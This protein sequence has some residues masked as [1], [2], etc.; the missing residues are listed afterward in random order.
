MPLTQALFAATIFT[1]AF[2]L[3]LVQPIVAKQI[4]PWFGGSAS[5][6]TVCMVF[7]QVLLLGGY[8][9]ADRVVRRL[10]PRAQAMLHVGLLVASLASLPIVADPAWKPQDPGA[11]TQHILG[12]LAATIGLPYFLLSTTGP[13]LQ[14]WVA[15]SPW[16]A[17]VYRYF[18]LSN[19]ASLL[20][21]LAYPVAIEPYTSLHDQALA[22]SIAY[23]VFVALCAGSALVA[24]RLPATRPLHAAAAAPAGPAEPA[25]GPGAQA[26]WL[27]LPA[28]GSWLLLA[29]TNHITQHVASI[30]F[31]WI[32]PLVVYLLTFILCFESDRWYRRGLFLPL[33]AVAL[34]LSGFGLNDAIGTH[35]KSA[36]PL[37]V[38]SL[39]VL[40]MVLHGE[41]AR[42]RPAAA[43]LTRFYLMLS[44]GGALGGIAVG[45]LAPALLTAYYELG[46]G[47]AIVAALGLAV[48]WPHRLGVVGSLAVAL[49][50]I[51]FLVEQVE[52]DRLGTRRIMRN[53]Y[54]TLLTHDVAGD[55]PRDTMRVLRHGSVIH[56]E[57]FVDPARRREPTAYYG[58]TSGAGLL[59]SNPP[60]RPVRVGVVGLGAGTLVT[61]GRPGDVYRLY[62]L[63]P[64][65]VALANEEFTFLRDTPAT[66]EHVPGDARL[67]M[68]R[69]P[70][71]GYD[72]LVIDAFSGGSVPVH[73]LT[74]EA[75]QIDLRHLRPDGVLVFH[76]TNRFLDLPPVLMLL[77][78]DAGLHAVR[79]H[80]DAEGNDALRRTDMLLMSRD[81][82]RLA[83][84]EIA[85]SVRAVEPI[86][87]LRVWTDDFN[88][89]I[90][91]L[92]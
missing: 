2:L 80:D 61:Y 92:K 75:L 16:G 45:L 1:G 22:W 9:Y 36:V 31:L 52:Y 51:G 65:V 4:L 78:R 43:H 11:P 67:S 64:Q 27:A 24:A 66:I 26:L 41:M 82:A 25:P 50:C 47:L 7:F 54:G 13:L 6:W 49:A 30:P 62:E 81:P 15:R 55:A 72:V 5:V 91:V 33:A 40:C 76:V 38:G 68:E 83:R 87:G 85:A 63:N 88:D 21:L 44:L 3:F 48:L 53:F 8:G 58:A 69:E 79:V 34:L 89:L 29:V 60:A 12:L 39:F 74:A 46:I 90:R 19:L 42:R 10:S 77:A 71:Q 56:G 70:P 86:A 20:S 14:S 32:L 73:L 23:A 37:Y 35:V 28:M 17:R 84:P 59:L 57:Q 18:A